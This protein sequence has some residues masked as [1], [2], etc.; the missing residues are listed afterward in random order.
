MTMCYDVCVYNS[1]G[2]RATSCSGF[3][4]RSETKPYEDR[5]E[6]V[7]S[8]KILSGKRTDSMC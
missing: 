8:T 7:V 4:Q 2:H 5:A 1:S 3:R 6:I